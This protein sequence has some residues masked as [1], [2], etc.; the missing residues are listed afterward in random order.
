MQVLGTFTGERLDRSHRFLRPPQDRAGL[1]QKQPPRRCQPDRLRPALQEH[2]A[3]LALQIPNL[4]TQRR[5]RDVQ[6]MGS[7]GDV[8]FLRDR[9]EVPEVTQFHAPSLPGGWPHA[10]NSA[11]PRPTSGTSH[12]T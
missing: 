12:C 8:L 2:D 7:P 6:T 10:M 3:Q 4:P 1:F 9:N 11:F 5:L